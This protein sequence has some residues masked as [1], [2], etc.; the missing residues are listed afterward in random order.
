MAGKKALF[1]IPAAV[2]LVLLMALI[3][4]PASAT[5]AQI[6][7]IYVNGT[8]GNNA[9][10][11]TQSLGVAPNGPKQTIQAGIGAVNP[12]GGTVIVAAGTYTENLLINS[13]QNLVGA[14]ALVTII[15][16]GG[17]GRVITIASDP[18]DENLISGFT[19]QNG[20]APVCISNNGYYPY[21]G[22]GINIP[23]LQLLPAP[24]GSISFCCSG[25]GI[26]TYHITTINDCTIRN[27]NACVGGGVFSRGQL[28][29]NRCTVSGNT[30]GTG[31][32]G[33]SNG[34]AILNGFGSG[35]E[36]SSQIES[37]QMWLTNCTISGNSLTGVQ[38]VVA[39]NGDAEYNAVLHFYGAGILN[40]GTMTLL[41]CTLAYNRTNDDANAHG[42]GFAN[43]QVPNA[44]TAYFKN[45]IVA[46]NTAG[47]GTTNNGYTGPSATTISQGNNLDSENSCGF[48]Q[49][50]DQTNINPFLGPL[51]NN[52]G[53][54]ST[55]A[56]TD[57]SPAYNRANNTGAPAT[58]QRGV[59]RP[60]NDICDVGAYELEYSPPPVSAVA[61]MDQSTGG[62]STAQNLRSANLNAKFLS[63]NPSQ[64]V[65]NQPV[66]ITTNVVN[67]GSQT[68]STRI[69]LK[70]NGQIEQ[71]KLVTVGPGGSRPVKFTVTKA[72]PGTYTVIIGN[73]RASFLVA[74]DTAGGTSVDGGTIVMILLGFL[75]VAIFIVVMLSFRRRPSN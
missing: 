33:I 7:T 8:T 21:L 50:T 45:T 64:T 32:G 15:D 59:T 39:V 41:N 27:N 44:L 31:G 40:Y 5:E 62:E 26:A 42:G 60:Q 28:Y 16:G 56:I 55:R 18:T 17:T 14:G 10:S 6:N 9:W 36:E 25:G 30:A 66:T 43:L 69:A 46:N 11:G 72:E 58:D 37:G 57:T 67:S 13:E 3:L 73:Q 52:G 12:D 19:I 29:M 70:I 24:A 4:V 2:V 22:A 75:V 35:H 65:A 38:A 34:V 20:D 47:D 51:Q 53:P 48:N 63:I 74:E 49:S 23:L 61:K 1:I 54:T 68:G 71:T